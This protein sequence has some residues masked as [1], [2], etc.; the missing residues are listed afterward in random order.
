MNSRFIFIITDSPYPPQGGAQPSP[1]PGY[2]YI[3]EFPLTKQ[4][5]SLVDH[6]YYIKELQFI[7]FLQME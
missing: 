7:E 4:L 2:V 6:Q 1:G 3:S 5:I